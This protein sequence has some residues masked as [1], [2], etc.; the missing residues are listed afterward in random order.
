V[1]EEPAP[2]GHGAVCPKVRSETA[3][4]D[5][6][7][8][9]YY[10]RRAA[11]DRMDAEWRLNLLREGKLQPGSYYCPACG[12]NTDSQLPYCHRCRSVLPYEKVPDRSA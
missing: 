2:Y 11:Q 3:A 10:A 4:C 1:S 5:C 8:D 6:G 7:F 12:F 9:A